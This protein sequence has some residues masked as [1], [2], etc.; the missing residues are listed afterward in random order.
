MDQSADIPVP[1]STI[2]LSANTSHSLIVRDTNHRAN[3]LYCSYSLGH[4]S[5]AQGAEEPVHFVPGLI[6]MSPGRYRRGKTGR[7]L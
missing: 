5:F 7:D 2:L 3:S 1:S 6:G 4:P